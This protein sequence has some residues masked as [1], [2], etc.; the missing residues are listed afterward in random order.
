MKTKK[1]RHT[2]SG[3]SQALSIEKAAINLDNAFL[4][5]GKELH[6]LSAEHLNPQ[7]CT[8]RKYRSVQEVEEVVFHNSK[9]LFG[10]HTVLVN[11]PEKSNG[12]F[13]DNIAPAGFLLDVGDPAKARF[14]VVDILLSQ[15]NFYGLV[16][17]RITKF[18]R[19]LKNQEAIDE[20]CDLIGRDKAARKVLLEKMKAE[21]IPAF[22]KTA[23]FGNSYILLV[24]DGEIKE[25]PE[26]VETY[27]DTWGMVKPLV[28]H[29][30]ASNRNTIYTMHPPFSE[31]THKAK[32]K[33]DGIPSTEEDHLKDASENVRAIYTN[34]KTTLLKVNN[35]L[36]FNPQKYY[37]SLRKNK[38]LAFFHFSKK[39]ISLVVMNSE[40][41]TRKIIKHHVVKTLT[42]KVQ[43]FWNG[44]SCTIVIE[45][46]KYLNEVIVLLKKMIAV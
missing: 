19:V 25:V 16:F 8:E 11:M 31:L 20:L 18:F 4:L 45:S 39:K 42:E 5:K 29:K 17:P 26:M 21:D 36:Q 46:E 9:T 43:K 40:K 3:G 7:T 35:Q 28:L 6:A 14:Y 22:L 27:P 44:P 15:Q 23:I 37:I 41:E 2:V 1:A 30:Y 13:G 33:R 38:N 12:V 32:K 34:V 24:M 10:Q